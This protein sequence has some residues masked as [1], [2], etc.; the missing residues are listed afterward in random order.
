[1]GARS[2]NF[3]PFSIVGENSSEMYEFKNGQMFLPIKL[4]ILV[5]GRGADIAQ[6]LS[7]LEI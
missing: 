4:P 1:M 5:T 2:F 3:L 6:A 7:A